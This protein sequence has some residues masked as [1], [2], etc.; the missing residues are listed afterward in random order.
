MSQS[1]PILIFQDHLSAGGAARAANRWAD[2]LRKAE[3]HVTQVTG[4]QSFGA[5][6]LLT[7]KPS[8]G[9]G[10]LVEVF[11]GKGGRKERVQAGLEDMLEGERL[12]EIWFH[13]IA[14]GGKW[15]W[16]EQMVSVARQYAPVVWT[17]HDM[18]A[19]GDGRE[20][21]FEETN[22]RMGIKASRIQKICMADG[23]YPIAVTAPSK[24]LA[25]LTTKIAGQKCW[26]L[27][28]PIDLQIYSPGDQAAAR[29]R[30]GLPEKGMVILAGAD[31]IQDPRKGLDLLLE[32]WGQGRKDAVLALFGRNGQR[33]EGIVNLGSIGTDD[34]MA[35]AYRAADLYVHPA[36]Q[37]NAPC[38]IQEALACGTPVMAFKVGGIPEMISSGKTGFLAEKISSDSLSQ[39]LGK[40]LRQPE[41]LLKMRLGCREKAEKE[42]NPLR[43]SN[44]I[45]EILAGVH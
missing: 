13:N 7:G 16:S 45:R 22:L 31:S 27:S 41:N 21:Y 8:R 33:R 25:N 38:T 36:R 28:N 14:G 1:S 29:R 39:E 11:T 24:W 12:K 23:R 5:T 19:L 42:W 34:A 2:V 6:R 15:G 4:D 30:F 3:R 32:A 18:W 44:M 43:L 35:D 20:G 26:H 9:W 37:E 10:R 40:C 17:L